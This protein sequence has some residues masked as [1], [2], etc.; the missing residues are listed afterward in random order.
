MA[1]ELWAMG[2]G[3]KLIFGAREKNVVEM[4]DADAVS[5]VGPAN[6]FVHTHLTFPAPARRARAT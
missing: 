5:I 1:R 3:V 6:K 2:A 4:A